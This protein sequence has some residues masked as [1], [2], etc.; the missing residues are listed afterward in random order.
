MDHAVALNTSAPFLR[1][2]FD[3]SKATS[4]YPEAIARSDAPI[5]HAAMTR[6]KVSL[7]EMGAFEETDLPD[8]EHTIGLKWVF[9][10]KT[11]SEGMNIQGKE[12]ARLVAQGFNQRPGQFDD[13]Y[14]PVAKMTS[15][16][17]LLAWAAVHDLD[18]F[19]FDCKTA[20]LHAKICHP[21]YARQIPGYPLSNPK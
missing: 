18:I 4:S 6:E 21:I 1:R 20:F 17:I 9:A 14:A 10:H 12:K 13:T 3:L 16:R 7:E 11:D 5:W 8:G 2:P 19:Q 15:V